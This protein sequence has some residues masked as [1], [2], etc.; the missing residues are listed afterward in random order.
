[1]SLQPHAFIQRGYRTSSHRSM[2]PRCSNCSSEVRAMATTD[3]QIVQLWL[4][5]WGMSYQSECQDLYT[6]T[7][8]MSMFCIL[9][10]FVWGLSSEKIKRQFFSTEACQGERPRNG[11]MI[12]PFPHQPIKE[13]D[14]CSMVLRFN[15]CVSG[16]HQAQR[17]GI[18]ER[19]LKRLDKLT[20][21]HRLKQSFLEKHTN[22]HD[23]LDHN[24]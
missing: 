22:I 11:D 2:W 7:I 17:L 6:A 1:M 15:E 4:P 19:E 20:L 3:L 18:H 13:A 16:Q 14:R 21:S 24:S 12:L 8:S 23:Q 9:C 5:L 10:I